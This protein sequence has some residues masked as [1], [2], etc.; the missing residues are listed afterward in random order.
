MI[1]NV[2]VESKQTPNFQDNGNR[3]Y[4]FIK[5]LDNIKYLELLGEIIELCIGL[6]I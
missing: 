5:A 4:E 2:C 6:N 1:Y 3:L